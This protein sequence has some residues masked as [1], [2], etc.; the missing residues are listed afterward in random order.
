MYMYI[1]IN[2]HVCLCVDGRYSMITPG[3]LHVRH[4]TT[5]DSYN[6]Y[7]CVTRNLLTGEEK[8]SDPA[9]LIVVRKCPLLFLLKTRI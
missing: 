2:L 5:A 8:T 1:D 6:A 7:R 9:Q 4:V 3:E